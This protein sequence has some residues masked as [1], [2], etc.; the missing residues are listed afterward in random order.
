[1]LY[2]RVSEPKVASRPLQPVFFI[3]LKKHYRHDLYRSAVEALKSGY[4]FIQM[5]DL[6]GNHW[7][8]LQGNSPGPTCLVQGFKKD[9]EIRS[10]CVSSMFLAVSTGLVQDWPLRLPEGSWPHHNEPFKQGNCFLYIHR[11]NQQ[12]IFVMI[13][14]FSFPLCEF[15][16]DF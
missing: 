5:D 13:T 11:N 14:V 4:A 6:M 12:F 10:C 15:N 3:Q 1:M 7:L 16:R 2:K 9:A 8:N